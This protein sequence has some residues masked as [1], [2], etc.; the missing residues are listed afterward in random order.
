MSIYLQIALLGGLWGLFFALLAL[1]IFLL[2]AL[3]TRYPFRL[4]P[5]LLQQYRLWD[6]YVGIT[7]GISGAI[8]TYSLAKTLHWRDVIPVTIPFALGAALI[9]FLLARLLLLLLA[10]LTHQN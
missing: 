4:H 7:A 3:F 8:L 10:K 1:L 2:K 6:Y 9:A 5:S